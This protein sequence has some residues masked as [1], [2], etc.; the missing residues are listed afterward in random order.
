MIKVNRMI[1]RYS[2][3]LLVLGLAPGVRAQDRPFVDGDAVSFLGDSITHNGKWHSYI[4]DYYLT[5]FPT[6][7]L[8]VF[9][10]GISGDTAAGALARLET[11]VLPDRPNVVAIMLG[12]NDVG[13]GQYTAGE[14]SE[15]TLAARRRSIDNYRA[16]MTKILARLKEAGVQ[17]IILVTPSP[18]DQTARSERENNPGVNDALAECGRIARELAASSGASVVDFNGPLTAWN[19]ARQQKDPAAT[20][21]GADR[22]HPGALGHTLMA[23]LF[24]TAQKAPAVVSRT[25]IDAANGL[26]VETVNAAAKVKASG[27]PLLSFELLEGALPFPI[28]KDAAEATT[29]APIEKELDQEVIAARGLAEGKYR[30]Y[31]DGSA[32]GTHTAAALANGINLALDANTPMFRQAQEVLTLNERRRQL[33][34]MLRGI[35]Q[36]DERVL[37]RAGVSGEDPMAAKKALDAYLEGLRRQNSPSLAGAE[38]AIARYLAYRP[39]VAQIRAEMARISELLNA[40][41]TPKVH[42]FEVE[43]VIN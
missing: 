16:N 10:T 25:V 28:D 20:L 13:R 41:R 29:I 1:Q 3:F 5:R 19:L 32:I 21:V 4:E 9:N 35:T 24:L 8:R 38:T 40:A 17:R 7:T 12:M 22:V 37:R 42:L 27:G 36:Y 15:A 11:D 39:Q 6:R 23:Y 43:Q 14:A 30:L 31:I 34:A 26:V 18:F 33:G 2:L